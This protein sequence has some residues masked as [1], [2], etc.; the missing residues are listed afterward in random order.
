MKLKIFSQIAV[1]VFLF[2]GFVQAATTMTVLGDNPFHNPPLQTVDDLRSVM[3]EAKEEVE[4]GLRLAGYPELYQPL[5]DQ[6]PR[7]EITTVEYQKGETFA[8][9]LYKRKGKGKV[10]VMKDMTWG[11]EKPF[12][13]YEFYIDHNG[14]R[15]TFTVPLACANLALKNAALAPAVRPVEPAPV[16]TAPTPAKD[17][18][19]AVAE[20]VSPLSYVADI[21]Y[22]H[23]QDPANYIFT[24]VGF[25]YMLNE[26]ISVLAMLGGAPKVDGSDGKSA[27]TV[28]IIGQ[29][30]WSCF[31]AGLGLGAWITS[32]DSKL[33][34][35]DDDLDVI[36]NI[37][38]RFCGKAGTLSTSIFLEARSGVD[39]LDDFSKYGRYGVGLRVNF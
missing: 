36:A 31:Y 4:K 9:M 38:Y 10:R 27:A 20:N 37:G 35:E 7:M 11:G 26:R 13:G 19:P 12:T 18:T 17:V 8:W 6:F 14:M 39:E 28:D 2:A 15:Y 5:M 30:N 24:R 29:Y 21:G 33:E 3:M 16:T 1:F 23:Q 32:G 25:D 22:L 34:A